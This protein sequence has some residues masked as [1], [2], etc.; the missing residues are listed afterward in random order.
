MSI[1]FPES[2]LSNRQRVIRELLQGHDCATKLKFLL[3][4]PI[5]SYGSTL[6]AE[7]LLSNVERSFTKTIYVVTSSDTEV[8]DEN[9]SHVGANSC[10]DLRSEDSTKSKKRSLTTTIKDRRGSYKRRRTAQTWTKISETIDDNHAWRKYGQKE[11]L[12]S[13]FP[14]SY[15]R[16]SRKYDQGCQAMKQVQRIEEKPYMYHTTYIGFHT[17]KDTLEAPQMVTY[18][19]TLD[20]FLV[21]SNSDSKV[22]NEKDTPFCSQIDPIIKQEYPKE[23]TSNDL[24]DNLDPT[25]WSDLKDLELYKPAI[26]L[27]KVQSDNA[28]TV[29]SCTDD[30][31][32]LRLDFGVFPSHF[33]TDFHFDE[34]HLL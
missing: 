16:C 10:N 7:E 23:D 1:L 13:K 33:S 6:S 27:S 14:R 8:F 11:I 2:V 4:N 5:G 25:L 24:K 12:N 28:D 3:Q 21:N 29:Y 34:N 31:Q 17:C 26:L 22:P 30:S 15:F 32:S 20:S 18:S 19:D 9:G